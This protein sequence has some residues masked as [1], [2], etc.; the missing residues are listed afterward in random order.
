MEDVV[1][2][3]FEESSVAGADLAWSAAVDDGATV[4]MGLVLTVVVTSAAAGAVSVGAPMTALAR[5]RQRAMAKVIWFIL[6]EDKGA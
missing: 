4:V 6:I 5:H 3:S 1:L 2:V